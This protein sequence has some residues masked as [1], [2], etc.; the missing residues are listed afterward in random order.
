MEKQTT[1]KTN[2]IK[3]VY[4]NSTS[5]LANFMAQEAIIGLKEK[6]DHSAAIG[7][8]TTTATNIHRDAMY[9]NERWLVKAHLYTL[10]FKTQKNLLIAVSVIVDMD[11]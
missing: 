4:P 9:I 10:G 8:M 2:T 3:V 5:G 1:T 11:A 6:V 7:M